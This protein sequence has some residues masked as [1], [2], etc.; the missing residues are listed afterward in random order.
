[1][2]QEAADVVQEEAEEGGPAVTQH[3]EMYDD[4]GIQVAKQEAVVIV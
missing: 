1:M 4:D 2:I 3:I